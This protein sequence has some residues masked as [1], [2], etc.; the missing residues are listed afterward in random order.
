MTTRSYRTPSTAPSRRCW[1]AWWMESALLGIVICA[2]GRWV[3]PPM[4]RRSKLKVVKPAA[5]AART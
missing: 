5:F 4:P 1:I 2:L 3:L